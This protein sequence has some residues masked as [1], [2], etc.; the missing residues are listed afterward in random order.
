MVCLLRAIAAPRPQGMVRRLKKGDARVF[1]VLAERAYGK[2][3]E[4][5]DL[6]FS[7]SIVEQL[8]G[9]RRRVLAGSTDAELRE[10]IEQLQRE[11]S[12]RTDS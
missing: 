11:L 12:M 3:K 4:Q 7:Q 1:K 10:R 9:A 8:Q 6:E 2:I 5:V